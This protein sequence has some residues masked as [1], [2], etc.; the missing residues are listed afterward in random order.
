M[1]AYHV[2]AIFIGLLL[3][4]SCSI[5]QN[6]SDIKESDNT[7]QPEE[8]SASLSDRYDKCKENK[9]N[10]MWPCFLEIAIEEKNPLI[11]DEIPVYDYKQ[12][13]QRC[14]RSYI[15]RTLDSSACATWPLVK[16]Y[17]GRHF[18][19]KGDDEVGIDP[20]YFI[21]SRPI[22]CYCYLALKENDRN[23]C[24]KALEEQQDKCKECYEYSAKN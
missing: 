1:K 6:N 22:S 8:E 19:K 3:L 14:Y 16:G 7:D 10:E 13:Q 18:N 9:L 15:D 12:T 5:S 23:V 2:L 17:D 21:M 11:C 4:T 20:S 24:E